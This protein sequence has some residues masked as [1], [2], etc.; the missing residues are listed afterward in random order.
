MCMRMHG[1]KHTSI[2]Y[3]GGFVLVEGRHARMRVLVIKPNAHNCCWYTQFLNVELV[4]LAD[5]VS[6]ILVRALPT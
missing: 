2:A 4:A 5:R 6:F 1:Y 3:T